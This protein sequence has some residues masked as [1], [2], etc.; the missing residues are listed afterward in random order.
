MNP[1]MTPQQAL[2]ILDEMSRRANGNRDDHMAA[3]MAL[4][5]LKQLVEPKA[6]EP[7]VA[8]PVPE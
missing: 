4:Q 1:Q 6:A 7:P 5:V 8:K 3:T 2:Q